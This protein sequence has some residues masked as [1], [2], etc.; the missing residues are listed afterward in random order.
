MAKV[1]VIENSSITWLVNYR[2]RS[3]QAVMTP[4]EAPADGLNTKERSGGGRK[5]VAK[6]VVISVSLD[7]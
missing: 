5:E 6:K 4:P 2:R 3:S 1:V 7:S